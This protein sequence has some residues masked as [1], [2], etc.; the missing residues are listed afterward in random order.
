MNRASGSVGLRGGLRVAGQGEGLLRGVVV[1][2]A[3]RRV[4][5]LV[6][7]HRRLLDRRG[8][9]LPVL[10]ERLQDLQALPHLV[11]REQRALREGPT[12]ELEG[13]RPRVLRPLRAELVEDE[14]DDADQAV[15]GARRPAGLGRLRRRGGGRPRARL[16]QV[17][18]PSRLPPARGGTTARRRAC[19]P[20]GPAPRPS[21]G[22]PRAGRPCRGRRDRAGRGRPSRGR[23]ASGAAPG[24]SR[25][26]RPTGEAEE[27]R[28]PRAFHRLQ[29]QPLWFVYR[30]LQGNVKHAPCHEAVIPRDA[31]VRVPRIASGAARRRH[32]RILVGSTP[33]EL[34]GMTAGD[35]AGDTPSSFGNTSSRQPAQTVLAGAGTAGASSEASRRRSVPMR[36]FAAFATLVLS[37]ALV[38]PSS[39]TTVAALAQTSPQPAPEFRTGTAVVLLDVIARDKKGRPVRDLKAEELQVFENDQRCE[40]RSF[41][42]VE[43][44]GTLEPGAAG[45]VAAPVT[46]RRAGGGRRSAGRGQARAVQP[47]HARLRPDEP[48][49]QPPRR[50]G[51]AR[52]RREGHGRPHA[53]RGVHDRLAASASCSRSRARRSPCSR[54]SRRPRRGRTSRTGLSPRRPSRRSRNVALESG[55]A[56]GRAAPRDRG[57]DPAQRRADHRSRRSPARRAGGLGGGEVSSSGSPSAL[58]MADG[59][60]R[61]M[62]GKWS[63]YPAARSREGPGAARRPQDP[64][65]LLAGPPGP[66]EPAGRL[67]HGRQ[68][69][70]PLERQRLLRGRAR[71][72]VARATSAASRRRAARGGDHLDDAADEGRE[73]RPR[74]SRRCRSRTPPE[75]A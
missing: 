58:R 9:A 18:A 32:V 60:Q 56:R 13:G 64:R 10:G 36:R 38:A 22:P 17:A 5:G 48:R 14:G 24:A 43:S 63:L 6:D 34:L 49:G 46:P 68:R 27:P 37:V 61:Q 72:A 50:E 12:R 51:R 28:T 44:E 26:K 55:A 25:E 11:D 21:A 8:E 45:A 71:P 57:R 47:R 30:V 19:R 74:P 59:L 20:R 35:S 66:A 65:L 69:G 15:V 62:E 4:A 7:P 23:P 1:P 52:L 40:V 54:R 33:T 29:P 53:G 41:R 39:L 2:R 73:R 70:Q 75:T 67:P 31:G 42:L 16:G 3:P